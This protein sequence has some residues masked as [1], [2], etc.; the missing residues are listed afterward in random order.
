MSDIYRELTTKTVADGQN[1]NAVMASAPQPSSHD[2]QRSAAWSLLSSLSQ[3]YATFASVSSGSRRMTTNNALGFES[4][5]THPCELSL[6]L[7]QEILTSCKVEGHGFWAP[8]E[9]V[10]RVS[11]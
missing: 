9:S 6:I 4:L 3:R 8:G 1:Q 2:S 7:C 10:N 11:R 5:V